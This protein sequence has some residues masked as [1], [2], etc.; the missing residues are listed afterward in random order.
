MRVIKLRIRL[1]HKETNEIVIL[2]NDVF[3]ALNGIAWY[4]I[5]RNQW[6]LLSYDQ[7]TGLKDKN[8]NDIY[9]GDFDRDGNLVRWC[10]NC[11]GWEF[12]QI[13]IPTNDICIPCHRCDGNFFFEDHITDFEIFSNIH[14]NPELL[15]NKD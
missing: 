1:K 8:G 7:F 10:Q 13:D 3:D 5:D 9:D 15:N 4:E 2:Y 14:I 11:N 12:A 6:A